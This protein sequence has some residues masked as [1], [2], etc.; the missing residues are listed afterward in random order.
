MEEQKKFNAQLS[1]KIYTIKNP[2]EQKLDGFQSEV[3]QKFDSLQ[4]SISKLTQQLDHQGEENPEEVCL[5]DTVVED[6][7]LQQ[8]EQ[9]IVENFESSG[10][11]VAI[12]LWEKNEAI[13]LLLTEEAVEENQDHNLPLPLTGSVY[14]LPS[15][16]PQ[17]QPKTPTANAQATYNPLPGALYPEP[18]HTV[19]IPATH[20]TLEA[21]APK[22]ESIPSALPVQ[23]FKK[24]VAFAQTF[25]TTSKK[26]AVLVRPKHI[27]YFMTLLP[28]DY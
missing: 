11:G 5:S 12:C 7:C 23:Y 8:L 17:S 21:P 14:I 19:F 27:H 24:S 26:M 2:L 22:D 9:G 15:P 28:K 13:L 16:A 18:L 1:K 20:F 3:G 10:I 6:H 25:A 4:C